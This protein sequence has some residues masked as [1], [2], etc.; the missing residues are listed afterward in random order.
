MGMALPMPIYY[1][2][3]T[4]KYARSSLKLLTATHGQQ[5]KFNEHGTHTRAHAQTNMLA[6]HTQ[7]AETYLCN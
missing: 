1:A 5:N 6:A 2:L 4:T 3:A 7:L